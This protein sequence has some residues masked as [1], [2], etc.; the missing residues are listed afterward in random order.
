MPPRALTFILLAAA[1]AGCMDSGNDDST[2]TPTPGDAT[3]GTEPFDLTLT[4]DFSGAESAE[5][6]EVP[7]GTAPVDFVLAFD[8]P[9]GAPVCPGGT[10]RISVRDPTTTLLSEKVA[11]PLDG[12]ACEGD[13][14]LGI[15][16]APGTWTVEFTGTG[17]VTG[18]VVFTPSTA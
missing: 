12:G 15:T 2:Q 7:N 8:A 17:A 1:L 11:A 4:H 10:A 16:L 13:E 3:V 6:F 18:R 14:Q 9:A 5:T